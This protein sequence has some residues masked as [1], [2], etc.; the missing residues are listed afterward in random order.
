M[1]NL[2]PELK[3]TIAILAGIVLILHALNIAAFSFNLIIVIGAFVL[4]AWGFIKLDGVNKVKRL[5][6]KQ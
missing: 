2:S 6:K 1:M 5:L 3:G 4:I